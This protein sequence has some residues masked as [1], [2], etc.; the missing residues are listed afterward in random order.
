[1]MEF[2]LQPFCQALAFLLLLDFLA[3][4]PL[5]SVWFSARLKPWW[6]LAIAALASPWRWFNLLGTLVL[7]CIFRH[8][9]IHERWSRVRRGGGAPG[10]MSHWA[11]LHLCTIQLGAFLDASGGL[12]ELALQVARI[13]LATIMICAGVYKYCV[14]YLHHDGMEYGR[15]NPFW[16]YH[17]RFF[18]KRNPDGF[19]PRL[20]NQLAC[21][22]E[23]VGG[24]CMLI[25]GLPQVLGAAAISLSFV[26]VSLFIRLGRLAWL[27]VLLPTLFWPGFEQSLPVGPGRALE[28]PEALL[29]LCRGLA[30]GYLALLPVV[31]F[32]QYA[33]LLKN[34][35]WPRPLQ[36]LLDRYANGVPIIMWRVFTP[37]VTN[38]YVRVRDHEGRYL[39]DEQT[40]SLGGWSRPWFKLRMLHVC[41]SIALTS[42]FTTL[43]YF[44]SRP[45]LFEQK[46]LE[47]SRSLGDFP[48]LSYEVVAIFKGE[49]R[50][51]FRHVE[52]ARVDRT[53]GAV[54]RERLDEHY[55][56]ARPSK[57]SPVREASAPGSYVKR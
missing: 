39:V 28:V 52:T 35:S 44:P 32:T 40:Y 45:E 33:N 21:L 29:Q 54:V 27:M 13:D 38:F 23:I 1:M 5:W 43:R 30:Y 12:A 55:D 42:V 9:F 48:S 50:F 51:E 57:Y 14:G 22:V 25:P 31:K 49:Q 47:Y 11:M 37:D 16:G 18:C 34:W 56:F 8:Y 15:V 4:Q 53:T 3:F 46:I 24:I 7:W 10:F 26:Y 36:Q 2:G 17:W 19:Y 20:M 41:E 6:L